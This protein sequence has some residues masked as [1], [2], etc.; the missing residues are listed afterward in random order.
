MRA[1]ERDGLFDIVRFE[2]AA[3]FHTSRELG[4]YPPHPEEG[5]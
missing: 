4:G 3:Q 1:R 2:S 5:A